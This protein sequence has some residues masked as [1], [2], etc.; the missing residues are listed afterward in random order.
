MPTPAVRRSQVEPVFEPEGFL[1]RLGMVALATDLTSERDAARLIPTAGAALH[2]ARVAYENP[3]TPENLRRMAPHLSA[4]AELLVPGT[5]L[6]G[7]YYSCTA[8]SVVIGD[9]PVVEAIRR[10]RPG[11]PVVTPPDAAACAFAAMG[12]R[13]IAVVTPYLPETTRPIVAYFDRRGLEVVSAECLSL[14]D[15]RQM[16]RVNAATIQA[17]VEAADC[18]EADGIF[19]S[20]TALPALGVVAALEDRLGK[21]VVTSNQAGF[22][23]LLHH[24]G[25]AP[26]PGAPG[27]L[28]T[29]SPP[30]AAA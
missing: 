29:L 24:A 5:L 4:A 30:D 15:D 11:V 18:A 22:W 26:A 21:P 6:A 3:T 23:R 28:F 19:V 9:E 2:V 8:A 7:I 25:I 14:T 20:C 12:V 1:V 10:V 13:R 27:R 17:A 16:A